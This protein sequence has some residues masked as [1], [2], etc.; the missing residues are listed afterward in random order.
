MIFS[1]DIIA[2]D[3]FHRY[4]CVGYFYDGYFDRLPNGAVATNGTL[5]LIS[6][7][8]CLLNILINHKIKNLR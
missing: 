8:K 6:M 1:I 5:T 7:K 4:F 2:L 3:I